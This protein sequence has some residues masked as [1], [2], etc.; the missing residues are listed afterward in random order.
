MKMKL[1]ACCVFL[2]LCSSNA[3]AQAHFPVSVGA[4]STSA[5]VSTNDLLLSAFKANESYCCTLYPE[6][7]SSQVGFSATL[8]NSS[9]AN[10][11]GILRGGVAPRVAVDTS[12]TSAMDNRVCFLPTETDTY[13]MT[14]ASASGGGASVAARCEKTS[15]S[16]GFNTN[17]TPFNFLECQNLSDSSRQ[18]RIFA[19][20]FAGNVLVDGNSTSNQYTIGA[21]LRRDFDIHS[22][23]GSNKFGEIRV[24]HDGPTGA[25]DCRVSR[26]ESTL[27]FKGTTSLI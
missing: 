9:N 15:V 27:E 20:D 10:Q 23:V 8:K 22:A 4:E 19:I 14:V 17:S 26:Y 1:L 24:L 25:L 7:G 2:L 6:A 5:L 3:F 13:S 21:G 16:G 18:I 11:T 12:D